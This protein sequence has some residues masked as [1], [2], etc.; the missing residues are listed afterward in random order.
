MSK[1]INMESPVMSYRYKGALLSLVS[2]AAIYGWYFARLLLDP[3]RTG[4]ENAGRLV[5]TV[6]L[7]AIV[8]VLGNILIAATSS[9]RYGPMDERERAFDRR[10][11]GIGYYL[12]IA[13]S[14]MAAAT[15]HLHA[16]PPAIANA[17]LLAIVTA[18]C[19]RQAIFL[20]LHHRAA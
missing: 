7:I 19:S 12:L 15:I 18:E 20:I 17:V 10:A 2:M 9:D 8:Q 4:A 5:E 11:T 6:L 13:G 16:G 1:I 3:R 14:L